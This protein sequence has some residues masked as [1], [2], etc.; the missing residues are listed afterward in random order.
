MQVFQGNEYAL[1]QKF[2][3]NAIAVVI[4]GLLRNKNIF[5]T[6]PLL[7]L[8]KPGEPLASF[9][10]DRTLLTVIDNP[11]EFQA[12]QNQHNLQQYPLI[13]LEQGSHRI[14]ALQDEVLAEAGWQKQTESPKTLQTMIAQTGLSISELHLQGLEHLFSESEIAKIKLSIATAVKPDEK[15]E[16]IRKMTLS[17]EP[18]HEKALLFLHALGDNHPSV[19]TEAA[20]SL[21]SIGV[22]HAIIE[23]ILLLGNS[24]NEKRQALYSLGI[25]FNKVNDFEKG[26]ILQVLL[27]VLRESSFRTLSVPLLQ[28][29]TK[30]IGNIPGQPKAMLERIL[31]STI[32]LLLNHIDSISEAAGDVLTQIAQKDNELFSHLLW[33]QIEKMDSRRVLAFLLGQ[34]A[35]KGIPTDWLNLAKKM[36]Y[37]FGLGDELDPIYLRL[38]GVMVQFGRQILPELI[39]RFDSTLRSTEHISIAKLL[40]L[41]LTSTVSSEQKLLPEHKNQVLAEYIKI[42]ARSPEAVRIVLLDN[43]FLSDPDISP[44]LQIEFSIASLMEIQ[45]EKLDQYAQ[46]VKAALCRIPK[47][48]IDALIQVLEKPLKPIQLQQCAEILGDVALSLTSQN[49][50]E[51][52]RVQKFCLQKIVEKVCYDKILFKNLGKVAAASGASSEM[53]E[54]ISEYLLNSIYSSPSPYLVLE[55]LGWAMSSESTSLESKSDVCYLFI[56]LMDKRLPERISQVKQNGEEK[57]FVFDNRSTAYTE[58]LPILLSGL[59]RLALSNSTSEALRKRIIDYLL[60]KWQNLLEYKVIWG[61]KNVIDLAEAIADIC[62]HPKIEDID[63]ISLAKALYAKVDIFT[64]T[65]FLIRILSRQNQ[66]CLSEVAQLVANKLLSFADNQ[67]YHNPEDLEIIMNCIGRLLNCQFLAPNQEISDKL[68]EQ[69]LYA[70]FDGLREQV[71]GV[72]ENLEK[73]INSKYLSESLKNEIRKRLPKKINE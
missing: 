55:G 18:I 56:A 57:V 2:Q 38:S 34:L 72:K 23:A 67:E 71:F 4:I 54:K 39:L 16:A 50:E 17:Q 45:K 48:A 26:V 5:L 49:V 33:E 40:D 35:S 62:Q 20:Q 14:L 52:T 73:L 68:H 70:M 21:R 42:F 1:K 51:L 8:A 25:I 53:A 28:T 47:S 60:K 29:L 27:T 31:M 69:L 43:Q 6:E 37:E 22:D 46:S 32:E 61:P 19:R 30:I 9:L 63:R 7:E 41:I 66:I 15:I 58:L 3:L 36:V 24:D 59:R 10:K 12:L 64:V 13:L 11:I 44:S 65:E